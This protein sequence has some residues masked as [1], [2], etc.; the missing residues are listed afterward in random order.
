MKKLVLL[1]VSAL[2]IGGMAMTQSAFAE[3]AESEAVTMEINWADFEAAALEV[4][5]QSQW[6]TFDEIAVQMWVPD[7]LVNM[8]LSEEDVENGYIGYFMTADESAAVG[9]QYVDVNGMSLEEYAAALPEFGA[10]EIETMIIN[11]LPCISYDLKENDTT[12]L[13]FVTEMGYAFEV[14]FAPLSDEGFASTASLIAASIQASE[15]AVE[16]TEIE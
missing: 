9:I 6:Y 10:T 3:E 5:P 7:V 15:E 16:E 8:E 11:G 13:T 1:T 2:M 4:A 12:A 14:S